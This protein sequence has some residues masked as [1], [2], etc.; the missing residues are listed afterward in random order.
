MRSKAACL[1]ETA[2]EIVGRKNCSANKTRAGP[3]RAEFLGPR[4]GGAQ[5]RGHAAP[6]P[7]APPRAPPPTPPQRPHSQLPERTPPAAREAHTQ[8]ERGFHEREPVVSSA[9]SHIKAVLCLTLQEKLSSFGTGCGGAD[10]GWGTLAARDQGG[11]VG[12]PA[13]FPRHK[14]QCLV[15]EREG[16]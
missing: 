3:G 5:G 2:T 12:M 1:R 7:P 14:L 6:P 4:R 15:A 16:R 9:D 11:A 8:N 13:A 10:G